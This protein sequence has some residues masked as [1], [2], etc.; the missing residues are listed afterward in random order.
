MTEAGFWLRKTFTH[1]FWLPLQRS[2]GD[3]F[4]G[5]IA[6]QFQLVAHRTL[7]KLVRVCTA[8]LVAVGVPGIPQALVP[9]PPLCR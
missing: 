2:F 9:V 4:I 6:Q 8:G 3:G 1:N 7:T 5:Q